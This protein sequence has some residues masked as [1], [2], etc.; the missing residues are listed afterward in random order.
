MNMKL[1]LRLDTARAPL[2]CN[3]G[4]AIAKKTTCVWFGMDP[5]GKGT[6]VT[7]LSIQK[8]RSLAEVERLTNSHVTTVSWHHVHPDNYKAGEINADYIDK[9]YLWDGESY[10]DE[11]FCTN[12]CAIAYARNMARVHQ[13]GRR[14]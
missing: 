10:V 11:F 14:R 13:H 12:R 2:C 6:L 8:P 9:A 5:K 3:C 4:K 1:Q 7:E